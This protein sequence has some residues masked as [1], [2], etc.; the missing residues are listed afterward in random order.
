[1]SSSCSGFDIFA[2]FIIFS[3]AFV[4]AVISS[5]CEPNYSTNAL[6][7]EDIRQVA[8]GYVKTL[9]SNNENYLLHQEVQ[10]WCIK[11]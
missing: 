8:F 2:V 10:F 7:L 6:K 4:H 3:L 9:L 1:M 11:P 5:L